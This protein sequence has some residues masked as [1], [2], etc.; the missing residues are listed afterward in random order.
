ME[1]GNA[2]QKIHFA[3]FFNFV[4]PLNNEGLIAIERQCALPLKIP[5]HAGFNSE[6]Q[7]WETGRCKYFKS[8]TTED[9]S[10]EKK[11]DRLF[12]N[13]SSWPHFEENIPTRLMNG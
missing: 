8:L 4:C 1:E 11:E 13:I 6:R 2:G 5:P 12:L 3:N 7:N 10:A 9:D